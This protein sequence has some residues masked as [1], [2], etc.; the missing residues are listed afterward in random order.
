MMLFNLN[1]AYRNTYPN[2]IPIPWTLLIWLYPKHLI[3]GIFPMGRS[4]SNFF[5]KHADNFI[6]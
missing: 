6:V 1:K 5:F 4:N 2:L 3:L